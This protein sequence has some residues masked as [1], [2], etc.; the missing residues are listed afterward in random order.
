MNW[1]GGRGACITP[2][3]PRS[4]GQLA[5]LHDTD[6]T[7]IAAFELQNMNPAMRSIGYDSVNR[8]VAAPQMRN[9][10]P[11]HCTAARAKQILHNMYSSQ[12]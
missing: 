10:P 3:E 1:R 5:T 8:S 2:A 7:S 6:T 9:I 11:M 4:W 12:D